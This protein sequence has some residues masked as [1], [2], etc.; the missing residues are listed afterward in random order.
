MYYSHPIH[1]DPDPE[2]VQEF[3]QHCKES[4]WTCPNC[5]R[6]HPEYHQKCWHCNPTG[7]KK[8]TSSVSS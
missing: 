3:I 8:K 6:T 4:R 7:F 2:E 5:G 1:G